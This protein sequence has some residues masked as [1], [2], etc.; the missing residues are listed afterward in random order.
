M[1]CLCKSC[2]TERNPDGECAD[3]TVAEWALI[4]TWVIDE[5]RLAVHKNYG[6]IE[7]FEV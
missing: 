4:G 3:E 1:F 7:I 6:V 2:A 5:I